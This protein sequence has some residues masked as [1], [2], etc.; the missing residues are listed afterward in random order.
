MLKI[1]KNRDQ[2]CKMMQITLGVACKGALI[3]CYQS[4]YTKL[5]PN[6]LTTTLKAEYNYVIDVIIK[7]IEVETILKSFS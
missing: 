2:T 4:D 5:A 3:C 1:R 6:R 7:V